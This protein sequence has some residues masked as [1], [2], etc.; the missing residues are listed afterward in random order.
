M[1][2][3]QHGFVTGKSCV[4]NLVSVL[5][6]IGSLLD[7]GGQIDVIYLDMSKAF[8]KVNHKLLIHKLRQFGFGG[9]LLQWFSSYLTDRVQRVTV[10]GATSDT[11]PV[12]SGVPQGSILGPL[13]FLLYANDLPDAVISSQIAM[14]AD[15]TK[16]FKAIKS[17]DDAALLQ[18]DLGNLETWSTASGLMFNEK[19]CKSQ[20]IT[21]KIK[22]NVATYSLN[23]NNLQSTKSER[24]L[25]VWIA[26]DLTWSKQV[27]EQSVRAN[28]LLG[29]IRRNTRYIRSIAVRRTIY[30]TLVRSQLGYA[31]Q[32]WAPQ[33]I[34]LISRLERIQRRATKYILKLYHFLVLIV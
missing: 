2:V 9:S 27:S 13:L 23:N 6:I 1:N 4:T 12:S 22:P 34:D 24:D 14:F 18:K 29:Y 19:K 20:S 30:L 3:C 31:T 15:D 11:L 17:P 26:A 32:V 21:R 16:I 5:N 8:D 28:K 33:T 10:L 7:D 25:G